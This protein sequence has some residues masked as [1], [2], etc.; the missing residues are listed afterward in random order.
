M[1]VRLADEAAVVALDPDLTAVMAASRAACGGA[2]NL[3]V[4]ALAKDKPYDV[5]SRFLAPGYGL[6]EDPATGSWHCVLAPIVGALL[7]RDRLSYSQAFPGRGAE[8]ICEAAGERVLITA[9]AVT[10]APYESVAEAARLM[11][12]RRVDRLPVVKDNRLI[13]IVTRADLVRAF[14]RGDEEIER[15]IADDVLGRTLWIEK[16]RVEVAVSR[17]AVRLDGVLHTRSDAQLLERLVGRVPGVVAVRSNV[18]CQVDDRSRKGR[19][20]LEEAAR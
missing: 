14:T 7:G 8:L 17:G 13:G 2:G 4:F 20:T 5:V 9:P 6:T 18:T 12:E 1:I 15:E 3:G 16:G 19:R 10:I 11:C